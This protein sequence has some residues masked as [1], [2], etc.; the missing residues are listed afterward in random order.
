M[1]AGKQIFD[2][3][4]LA[5]RNSEQFEIEVDPA[6]LL[7]G[8]I[9][10]DGNEDAVVATRFAVTENVRVI[11]RMEVERTITVEGGIVAADSVDQ[12]D[13]RGEAVG[14]RA[15]PLANFILLAVEILLAPRLGGRVFAELKGWPVDTVVGPERR[16]KNEALHKC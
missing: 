9:E 5:M 8:G 3:E 15:V 16:G 14:C 12:S 6:G 7:L 13:Q 4:I 11:D 10:V 2:L 1:R